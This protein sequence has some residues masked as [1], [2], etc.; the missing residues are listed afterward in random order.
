M[1]EDEITEY[2]K[3]QWDALVDAGVVCSRLILDMTR[4]QALALVDEDGVLGELQ[5]RTVLCLANGGGQQ[6]VAFAL[7]GAQVTVVDQSDK[8]LER[9]REAAKHYGFDIRLVQGDIR[10]LSALGEAEFDIVAQGYSINYVSR[11]DSVFDEVVR[12]LKPG[13]KYE[14]AC[15][16][17]FVHGSWVDGCW[18]S[19]WQ[20]EDLWK[21]EG[22]PIRLP[23]VEGA[24]ITTWDQHWNFFNADGV[25]KRVR[26]PQEFRHL[27]STIVNGLIDRG[28]TI[29]RI[30]EEPEG[31]PNAE[32]G[33]WEHYVSFA[34]PWLTIWS[35]KKD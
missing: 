22:Y 35:Q 1:C 3:Q 5:G 34:P 32:P 26:S 17:P 14:L 18:G 19:D 16:N 12:V 25:E 10:D 23:Y 15:H 11:I 6:S 9:D 20:K 31:D 7:L 21:G 13:G 24:E 27:L 30:R 28:L 33:S 2:N 8:Q 29:L 4:E